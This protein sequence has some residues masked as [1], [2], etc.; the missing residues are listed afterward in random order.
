MK[1]YLMAL[2]LLL[3]F[4]AAGQNVPKL[5]PISEKHLS[6]ALHPAERK[7]KWGFA[8]EKDNFL[9]K[10]VFDAVE[11]YQMII[12][13]AND[14]VYLAKVQY[15]GKWALLKRDGTF[16]LTPQFDEL[17]DFKQ[18]NAVFKRGDEYGVLNYMGICLAENF[19]FLEDFSSY[20]TAWFQKDFDWGVLG[21]DGSVLI[22]NLFSSPD[23]E[24][25][26]GDLLKVRGDFLFGLI[27]LKQKKMIL[28]PESDAIY[29]DSTCDKLVVYRKDG[30][31]GCVSDKGN[32]ICKPEYESLTSQSEK[33]YGRIIVQKDGKY[34]L[35]NSA[36]LVLIPARLET[37][38]FQV[39]RDLY[40]YF[41][42]SNQGYALPYVYFHEVHYSVS[43][44]DDYLFKSTDHGKYVRRQSDY[45]YWMQRHLY[46]AVG[47]TSFMN[48][49]TKKD[50]FSVELGEKGDESLIHLKRMRGDWIEYYVTLG[51]DMSVRNYNGLFFPGDMAF[52]EA[53][54]DIHY[55][56]DDASYYCLGRWFTSLS[57][58]VDSDK[59]RAFDSAN[60]T[61]ILRNWRTMTFRVLYT[62]V[63]PDSKLLVIADMYIDSYFMRR[64]I[65]TLTES[66]TPS[67]TIAEDGYLYSPKNGICNDDDEQY[68]LGD[69]L[70][71]TYPTLD[72]RIMTAIYSLKGKRLL[73]LRGFRPKGT[74]IVDGVFYCTG[75]D[76]N[77]QSRVY[78]M[79]AGE[80][81]IRQ[82]DMPFDAQTE[83]IRL[84]SD[85]VIVG[86]VATGLVKRVAWRDRP[87]SPSPMLRYVM[88]EW[89]GKK[90]V[91]I[92][93]NYW[94]QMSSGQFRS[95][96]WEYIPRLDSGEFECTLDDL[97]IRVYPVNPQ[98][99]ALYAVKEKNASDYTMKYGYIGFDEPF[100]TSPMF[101]EAKALSGSVAEVRIGDTWSTLSL[102]ELQEYS[103]KQVP[104]DSGAFQDRLNSSS[105]EFS[106]EI[107]IVEE[108]TSRS[109]FSSRERDEVEIFAVT[110]EEEEEVETV[111]FFRVEVKPTFQGGDPNAFSKW[112]AEHLQYPAIAK[113][114]G[115]RGRVILQFTICK[116]GSVRN[117]KVI[118]GV[119]E[120]LDAEAVRVVKSSPKWTPGK[121]RGRPVNV[122][123]T[124]P[125]IFDIR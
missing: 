48:E 98:G 100:F 46:E 27:S 87:Q 22:P 41:E 95:V 24:P 55:R 18:N 61:D 119:D 104:T 20:E 44:F 45:P 37:N 33:D 67:F 76:D 97:L 108:G 114:N 90:I 64:Y 72:G 62:S 9:V 94:N 70:I 80:G 88:S 10:A 63:L 65:T 110:E 125:V 69:Q 2:A 96:R 84:T 115:I 53:L 78:C 112:V 105:D 107:V 124:F 74:A 42:T 54:E 116:D 86:D 35:M 12:T 25:L 58:S 82:V 73:S 106:D 77:G 79:P 4:V 113:E 26:V 11:D 21:K 111:E 39:P 89:D 6:D 7:G 60:G 1:K 8:N 121:Q 14:T 99:V 49:W 117:V 103:S 31:Y 51:K 17:H 120:A 43:E 85:K 59:I 93:K 23:A 71:S 92:S 29:L 19:Q 101:D 36:G 32:V 50:A 118:R 56:T 81:S 13:E 68:L 34:G 57:K 47:G 122:T 38:Q 30:L 15:E 123:Y 102:R 40:K 91:A 5:K 16:L 28:P 66:G 52:R 109:A 75:I 3:S 83:G